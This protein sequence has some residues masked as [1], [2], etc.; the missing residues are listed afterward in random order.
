MP[1]VMIQPLATG[2]LLM[3][4]NSKVT[5]PQN[6]GS[7]ASAVKSN[8]SAFA[9]KKPYAKRLG[10]PVHDDLLKRDFTASRPNGVWLTDITEHRTTWIPV[11]V[12]T[13][14]NF[15]HRLK[16]VEARRGFP[17]RALCAADY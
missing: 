6:A 10:P 8:F 14:L 16:H 3:S 5:W 13:R 7:G 17:S 15:Q 9:K 2:S 4:F 1:T 12:A 11:V